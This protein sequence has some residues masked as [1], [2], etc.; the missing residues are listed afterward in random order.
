MS[1]V[2]ACSSKL[3][4]VKRLA[5]GHLPGT[6]S[7]RGRSHK[8]Y[9]THAGVMLVHDLSNTN[10]F[11][12]LRKWLQAIHDVR[13]RRHNPHGLRP[14]VWLIALQRGQSADEPKRPPTAPAY[15][16]T[17]PSPRS[18]DF[19][20]STPPTT[21]PTVTP[22]SSAKPRSAPKEGSITRRLS[23]RAAGMYAARSSAVLH[24]V[25]A[26]CCVAHVAWRMLRVQPRPHAA[27]SMRAN[28][29][30]RRAA[31]ASHCSSSATRATC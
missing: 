4:T 27:S 2:A 6:G 13:R 24:M 23:A 7:E 8:A 22:S 29:A 21:T 3:L 17:S 28:M 31:R 11:S 25:H 15:E 20:R 30:L 9:R 12:N 14:A 26:A 19:V 5:P 18:P 10:S 16:P 1:A